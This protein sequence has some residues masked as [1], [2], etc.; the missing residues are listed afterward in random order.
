[1]NVDFLFLF[2]KNCATLKKV[3]LVKNPSEKVQLAAVF[4][5]LAILTKD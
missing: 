4:Q 1:L 2:A 5:S 3:M